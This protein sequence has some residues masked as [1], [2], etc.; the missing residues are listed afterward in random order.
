MSHPA[1]TGPIREQRFFAENA[2]MDEQRTLRIAL[3][4]VGVFVTGCGGEEDLEL[5]DGPPPFVKT[6]PFRPSLPVSFVKI[7]LGHSHT[8]G[9]VADGRT[10]CMGLND[11][12]QLGT[13]DPMRR[14]VSGMQPCT[15]TPLAV[16]TGV[17]FEALGLSQRYSCGLAA[18]GEAYC[19]GFGLGGQL[20]DGLRTSSPT[21]VRVATS[22][23]F[24]AISHG[25]ASVNTCA[26]SQ[27]GQI[28]CWGVG[29]DGLNGNG[30]EDV[31]TTPVAV[32]TT[33]RMQQVGVG[34]FSVC[35]LAESGEIYCW[36][37]NV[38][39]MLGQGAP[40]S[41]LVPLKVVG[42]RQYTALAVGAV[43]VCALDTEQRA[44]CWGSPINVGTA[45]PGMQEGVST[46]QAVDGGRRYIAITAGSGHT[47]ALDEARAAWCWGNGGPLGDGTEG[48]RISP[49]LVAGGLQYLQIS[50]GGTATCG[51][52]TDGT[53]ACWGSNYYGQMGFTPGDP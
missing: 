41:S 23:R 39:G 14:C 10:F 20:G 9:R 15:P 34:Q 31:A 40:V 44:W 8:C 50:A 5:P 26:I 7:E 29:I 24:R 17:Q 16:S 46:P 37:R 28:H 13:L 51:I 48:I 22:E 3:L 6:V 2:F 33:V 32:A 45:V 1:G 11:Y 18:S 36:G 38:Y 19:W 49:V 21:P 12:G 43:H 53:L 52:V 27:Q 30:T 47:C 4:A 42:G 35:A 25:N